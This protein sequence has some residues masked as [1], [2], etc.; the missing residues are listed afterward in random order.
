MNRRLQDPD[1]GVWF[2]L[3][4]YGFWGISP[5]Y[6]K[7]VEFAEPLEILAHRIVWAFVLLVV[8]VSLRRRWGAVR[9]LTA[10]GVAWLTVSAVL[11][12]INWGVF[13]WALQNDR[14]VETSL[15]YYINPLVNI[16]LGGVFLGERLRRWQVLAVGLAILGVVNEIVSVG[17]LPW[18]GLA[19]AFSFGFYGLVRKKIMV[20]SAVGLGVETTLLLQLAIGYLVFHALGETSTL[21]NGTTDELLLLALGGFVTVFPLVCFAAAALRLSLTALGLFQYL[22]PTV[23][24]LVAVYYYREPLADSQWITFGCI[25]LAL[26]IFS[27]EGLYHQRREGQT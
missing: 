13:I 8:L 19:L 6:F 20:D 9:R 1:R 27:G 16:V 12:T 23:T 24:L 5:V 26:V 14:I 11:V 3:A 7:W 2:A 10:S 15:G 25:W 21:A 18:A 4:A 17:V 22:A